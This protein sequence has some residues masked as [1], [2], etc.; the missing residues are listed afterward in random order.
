MKEMIILEATDNLKPVLD[1]NH[2][3]IP[4][5]KKTQWRRVR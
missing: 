4:I 2:L 5:P 1:W 3:L